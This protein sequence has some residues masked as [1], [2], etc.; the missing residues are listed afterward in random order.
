MIKLYKWNDPALQKIWQKF[1]A[2]NP[3]LFPYSSWEYNEQIYKY[4]KVKP[5]SMFQKNFFCVY[6]EEKKPLVL[7]PLYL[8][9]NKLRLFGE[10][11]SG[12]GHLD[13]LYDAE[14][15]TTQL[16]NAFTELKSMF[17]G[18]ILELRMINERSKLFSFLQ[19]MADAGVDA[20]LQVKSEEERVCVKI[21]F[22]DD[23]EEYEKGGFNSNNR[24]NLHRAYKKTRKNDLDM[25]L[26]VIQ[27]PF[28]D[29]SL[30]SDV[31]KIYTKRESE[32]KNRHMDFIPYIKHR[33]F[34]GLIWAIENLDSQYTF[35]FFLNN[36]LAAF[37]T[38]FV[39]NYN[40]IVFPY[41]S[42]DSK[43]GSYTPGKLMI[44][45]SIKYLQAHNSIRALD[46]SRGDER[47]KFEMGGVRHYNYRFEIQL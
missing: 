31:M 40:E 24:N 23:Y 1:Y 39:T 4:I 15:T 5:S 36:Q 25:S 41:V 14:I 12:A 35:C 32:R 19:D 43:F 27:G 38:G 46:M 16:E 17:S 6:E 18:R 13:L 9:K 10:N 26:K 42:I 28:K 7:F 37:M 44:A 2:N 20:M 47:Y 11:I 8:K 22:P 21:P 33:Y 29:K 34:S 30:L 3:Y 45:E